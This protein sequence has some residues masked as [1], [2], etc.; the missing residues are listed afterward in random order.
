VLKWAKQTSRQKRATT[1]PLLVWLTTL[2][3]SPLH[4]LPSSSPTKTGGPRTLGLEQEIP[5]VGQPRVNKQ[6][7][8]PPRFEREKEK[9]VASS[10]LFNLEWALSVFL[11]FACPDLLLFKGVFFLPHFYTLLQGV[12][13]SDIIGTAAFSTQRESQQEDE[14]KR[15]GTLSFFPIK[16][17]TMA[18]R[19]SS[20]PPP[21]RAAAAARAPRPASP[22]RRRCCPPARGVLAVATAIAAASAPRRAIPAARNKALAPRAAVAAAAASGNGPRNPTP[23]PPSPRAVE[24]DFLVL[25]SGIAGLTFALRAADLGTVA[26]VT[27]G[28][29]SDGCTAYA[30]GGVSAVLSASDS[31]AAHVRDT[32]LAG[33]GAC[34][35]AAVEAVCGDGAEALLELV[36]LGARFDRVDDD[37]D[38]EGKKKKPPPPPPVSSFSDPAAPSTAEA[39][40]ALGLHLTREGGHSA[41]RVAHAADA[42]GA[43]VMRA[44]LAAVRAHPRISLFEHRVALDLVVA[45]LS[46]ESSPSARVCLGADTAHAVSRERC[47]FVAAATALATGG[48]GRAFPLSTNPSVA[49]GDGLAMALR[50]GVPAANLEFVQF[51]PTALAV[52]AAAAPGQW[53]EREEARE[54]AGGEDPPPLAPAATARAALV[55]EAARG[56][57]GLLLNL[58]GERFMPLYDALRAE[59]APRD[60]VA[61]AIHHQMASRGEPHVLL[62]LRPLGEAAL[63][64]HFPTVTA[65]CAAAGIDPSRE[66]VPV[67][68]AQHYMCGGVAAGLAGETALAGL[69]AVGEC[70]HSGLHGG[71]R[72]A[73]NSLLEGLVFARRA[74]DAGDARAAPAAARRARELDGGARLREA[75]AAAPGLAPR[76]GGSPSGGGGAAGA[77]ASDLDPPS[78]RAARA[79]PELALWI[80]SRR[81]AAA[82]ALG[83]SAG[84][85]RTRAGLAAG[86]AALRRISAEVDALI[87]ASWPQQRK[88]SPSSSS[89]NAPA[90]LPAMPLE[91][92]ELRN[93]IAVSEGIVACALSRRES[94]GG[95][96]LADAPPSPTS[97]KAAAAEMAGD[98]G[99]EL[100]AAAALAAAAP[101]VIDLET[102][103]AICAAA[104]EIGSPVPPSRREG[105]RGLGRRAATLVASASASKDKRRKH[106]SKGGKARQQQL[107]QTQEQHSPSRSSSS[108]S[109]SRQP[110]REVAVR[111]LLGDAEGQ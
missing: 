33:D 35:V 34:N 64:R 36:A 77:A 49:T 96:Y 66:P 26:V 70:A 60:V 3:S 63:R 86:A 88:A 61:R 12:S 108:P 4:V 8:R 93:V 28:A 51:H 84:I 20:L 75:A 89:A 103:R 68:P 56:E 29:A 90:A 24:T 21:S 43:E 5:C 50:A 81:S 39:A 57:G 78:S 27:K 73:S 107:L 1:R 41:R 83:A 111:S 67:A 53:E 9:G 106:G 18:L 55:T 42:T 45:D 69:F 40:A 94:V 32:L 62:D 87:E 109:P 14:R 79:S 101:T 22:L 52:A 17:T 54:E 11:L 44:L 19:L 74:A 31:V 2:S 97:A 91:L 7:S 58:S 98:A 16:T 59:L 100:S 46:S 47:R 13:V 72:L 15:L 65:A 102:A 105:R 99:E 80:S 10:S 110:S 71:N 48:A 6:R 30:Q 37:D 76:E 104:S 25:G 85:V 95:H 38:G 92:N 82:L 23:P